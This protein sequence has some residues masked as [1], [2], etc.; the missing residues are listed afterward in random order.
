MHGVGVWA[1]R[2]TAVE[3]R[4]WF[5]RCCGEVGICA[6]DLDLSC[7]LANATC[8]ACSLALTT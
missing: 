7:Y 8:G 6:V 1:A 5:N 3:R 2:V 4:E